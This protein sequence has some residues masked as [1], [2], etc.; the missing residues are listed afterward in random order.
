MNSGYFIE[1]SKGGGGGSDVFQP[2]GGYYEISGDNIY[3]H[4][5][6]L[7]SVIPSHWGTKCLNKQINNLL[8]EINFTS[9]KDDFNQRFN[10]K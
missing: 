3:L 6:L 4:Q 10:K 9:I 5:V 2:Q 1:G 7:E 8:S